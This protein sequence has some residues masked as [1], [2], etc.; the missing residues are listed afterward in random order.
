MASRANGRT[1]AAWIAAGAI[2][3]LAA[4]CARER[5]ID[6]AS[7]R[8]ADS[9]AGNWTTYGRTYS[10]QRFSPLRDINEQTVGRLALAWSLD[11]GTLRALEATPLVYDGVMYVTSAWSL[12]YAVD[13]STGRLLWTYDPH[14]PKDYAKYVCCDVVNRGVALY[15]NRVFVGA[16]DG[17]L[18]ALDTRN[19]RPIW[20]VQTTPIGAPYAITG[21]P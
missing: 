1:I 4:S 13:A 11:L 20:E 16:L 9:D 7:L 15:R 10:E 12:V 21:A 17:R 8:A 3:V 19:G 14:V 5:T 6:D 18:I 2:L